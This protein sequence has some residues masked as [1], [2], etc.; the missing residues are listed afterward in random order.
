[1][2]KSKTILLGALSA[3]IMLV[4]VANSSASI[5]SHPKPTA[6]ASASTGTNTYI[7][8]NLPVGPGPSGHYTVQKQP[9]AGSCHYRYTADKQPLP[10][11]NCTPGATN[12]LVT[13]ANISTTICRS[14]YTASIRPPASITGREKIANAASYGN[15]S[16]LKIQ[17]MDH[18]LSLELG[19]DPN[20]ALNL[21]VEPASPGHK[22]NSV[23]N[24]KDSVE[25]KLNAAIC[26]GNVSLASAQVAIAKDWTTALS[27]LGLN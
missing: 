23:N 1:M 25:N 22:G 20:S 21:W 5:F 27:T 16:S 19:G 24:P 14:G 4:P 7:S 15:T 8:S 18:L 10:D 9:P 3:I 12:P 17:E 26:S 2:N 11:P 13:Q 6:S